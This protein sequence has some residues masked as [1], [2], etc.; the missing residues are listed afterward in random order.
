MG[1]TGPDRQNS[2]GHRNLL[3]IGEKAFLSTP[4]LV[5]FK[6]KFKITLTFIKHQIIVQ[7]K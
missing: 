4:I 7:H 2:P 5:G 1:R 6:T 3:I